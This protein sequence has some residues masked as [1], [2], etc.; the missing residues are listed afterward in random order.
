ME[1]ETP[2]PKEGAEKDSSPLQDGE[3]YP[4]LW[5]MK[6]KLQHSGVQ[7]NTKKPQSYENRRWELQTFGRIKN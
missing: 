5:G 7:K 6:E 4:T 1:Q 2:V 3:K